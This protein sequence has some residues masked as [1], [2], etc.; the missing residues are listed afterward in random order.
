MQDCFGLEMYSKSGPERIL[1]GP[2]SYIRRVFT[3]YI[4]VGIWPDKSD[5]L[6]PAKASD[7]SQIGQI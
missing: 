2:D 7:I 5:G 6:M 4:I 3:S 1:A